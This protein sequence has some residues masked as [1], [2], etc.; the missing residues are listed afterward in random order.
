LDVRQAAPESG[1]CF[2]PAD[3]KFTQRDNSP[4]K[5]IVPRLSMAAE[6]SVGQYVSPFGPTRRAAKS[7]W[8]PVPAAM[9]RT[10]FP[11]WSTAASIIISFAAHFAG[12]VDLVDLRYEPVAH[13]SFA[14]GQDDAR[15]EFFLERV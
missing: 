15:E 12:F 13:G 10:L 11:R 5:Q 4:L 2:E 14:V 7:V 1:G 3:V 6:M 9:S 8:P